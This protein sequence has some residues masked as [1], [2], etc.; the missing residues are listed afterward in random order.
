M[1]NT[2]LKVAGIISVC[3]LVAAWTHGQSVGNNFLL[4]L[5]GGDLLDGSSG[6][7]T[8]Q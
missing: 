4:D 8:A 1:R 2:L 7:L 3:A 5:I 6:R